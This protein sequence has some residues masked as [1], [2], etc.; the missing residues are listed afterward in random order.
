MI[1]KRGYFSKINLGDL[2]QKIDVLDL[3]NYLTKNIYCFI[4][5][6]QYDDT[7]FD[8][9]EIIASRVK[10]FNLSDDNKFYLA[11]KF[12]L[13]VGFEIDD[14]KLLSSIFILLKIGN[15]YYPLDAY[16]DKIIYS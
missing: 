4:L 3:E 1:E 6:Y 10:A 11:F 15:E 2:A 8:E 14:S 13:D 5:T 7:S 12:L 9:D 16:V